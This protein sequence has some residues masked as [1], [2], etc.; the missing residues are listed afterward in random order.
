MHTNKQAQGR[1]GSKAPREKTPLTIT[2]RQKLSN[3]WFKQANKYE[4]QFAPKTQAAKC[5][6]SLSTVDALATLYQWQL[7]IPLYNPK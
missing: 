7:P 3:F 1:H 5:K 4:Q 2:L 6:L